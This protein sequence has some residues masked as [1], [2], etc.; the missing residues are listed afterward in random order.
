MLLARMARALGAGGLVEMAGAADDSGSTAD[1][2]IHGVGCCWILHFDPHHID[3]NLP[4]PPP[5]RQYVT[6]CQA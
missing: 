2:L 3:E 5:L 6:Q 4:I 1:G